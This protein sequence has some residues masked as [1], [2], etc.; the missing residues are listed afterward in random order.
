MPVKQRAAKERRPRFSGEVLS[1]F[2]ELER[3]PQRGQA[4]EDGSHRLARAL[5]LVDQWWAG[6][7]VN[8]CG[9][10]PCH[11]SGYIAQAG[12]Y[13]VRRVRKALLAAAG[14]AR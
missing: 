9:P 11:P 8:D 4:F 5:G 6:N 10:G 1:L 3:M 7:H 2:L 12:W 13:E 14:H